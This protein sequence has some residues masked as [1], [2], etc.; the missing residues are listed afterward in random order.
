MRVRLLALAWVCL[1]GC[2]SYQ[3]DPPVEPC[4]GCPAGERCCEGE[5]LCWPT[6]QACPCQGVVCDEPPAPACQDDFT[7]RVYGERGQC[8]AGQCSY[9]FEDL[10]CETGVCLAGACQGGCAGGG[11]VS[12]ADCDDGNPCTAEA[13]LDTCCYSD[14]QP[15][16]LACDDGDECTGGDACQ[17]GV[18]R[19]LPVPGCLPCRE[20]ADCDDGNPC[21]RDGCI[22][23]SCVNEQAGDGMFCDDGEPCTLDDRCSAGACG[24]W[25]D[26][27]CF[28]CEADP[29]LCDDQNPCTEDRC[30]ARVCVSENLE[31]AS[32]DDGNACSLSSACS[33]GV[34]EGNDYLPGCWPCGGVHG[35]CPG[36]EV[37]EPCWHRE[38][39]EGRCET[40]YEEEGTSCAEDD[41]CA[42]D[43][44][45]QSTHCVGHPVGVLA[46]LL[47]SYAVESACP[48]FPDLLGVYRTRWGQCV[49]SFQAPSVP[50]GDFP[51]CVGAVR[52]DG[53]LD[54][55]C[56]GG[57]EERSSCSVQAG[58]DPWDFTAVCDG[59]EL[60]F[61][62]DQGCYRNAD[63]P[64]G[65]SCQVFLASD[66]MGGLAQACQ[67]GAGPG[68]DNTGASCTSDAECFSVWCL[69]DLG[70]CNGLC[71]T[72]AD[73][74]AVDPTLLCADVLLDLG[75]GLV[76]LLRRCVPAP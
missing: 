14:P 62:A 54:L 34:C 13:C 39:I 40:I 22:Q 30:E 50:P 58:F 45:C 61:T 51:G 31:G 9:P 17:T 52:D 71:V 28:G 4:G 48:W 25:P 43:Y 53:G 32:C 70:I 8:G 23:G 73:C 44:R 5:E 16:G 47:S 10:R 26:P 66:P 6:G 29:G 18:C 2:Q 11:C 68:Y 59:C 65:E 60:R 27:S 55:T 21:T 36:G 3:N 20:D 1:A 67:F 76:D 46:G 56:V 75:D 69:A 37:P 15:D 57:G 41:A 38:C 72:D 12:D 63:C 7:L 35:Y 19:G 74:Q 42:V 33:Q 24:G 49:L 64:P